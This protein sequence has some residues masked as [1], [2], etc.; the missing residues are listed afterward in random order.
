MNK[1]KLLILGTIS[2]L[3]FAS[4]YIYNNVLY[5]EARNIEHEEATFLLSSSNLIEQYK[6]DIPKSDAKY[7]NR[8]IEIE[9][10]ITEISSS[11]ITLDG[12]V[13]C[14]FDKIPTVR[15]NNTKVRIKGRCIG[16]D[17]M[18]NEVKLDQCII[19]E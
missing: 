18:F 11:T 9:G 13:F 2:L 12:G 15:K 7:L 3:C 14:S 6:L 8:T 19:L 1:K 4:F 17:E 16:F 10:K 5:K